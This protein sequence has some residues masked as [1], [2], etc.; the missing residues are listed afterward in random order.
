MKCSCLWKQ[1]VEDMH[2]EAKDL[3]SL[4]MSPSLTK[5]RIHQKSRL[6]P[7]QGE[8]RQVLVRESVNRSLV[9]VR[10]WRKE[11]HCSNNKDADN[12][13]KKPDM[14]MQSDSISNIAF[15]CFYFFG[16][17]SISPLNIFC[18]SFEDVHFL[19]L[20]VYVWNK[21]KRN[22]FSSKKY[23]KKQNN[24]KKRT[25]KDLLFLKI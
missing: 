14:L 2:V 20:T 7:I 12:S 17:K 8:A 9:F 19:N 6:S 4:Q 15:F 3:Y 1:C 18:C 13:S 10:T 11:I 23:P 5:F 22:N 24:N 25:T 21:D 16:V